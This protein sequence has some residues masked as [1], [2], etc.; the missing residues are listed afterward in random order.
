MTRREVSDA[1]FEAWL[2]GQLDDVRRGEV[3]AAVRR[4]PELL[5]RAAEDA[6]LRGAVRAEL[7]GHLGAPPPRSAALAAALGRGVRGRLAVRR[8]APLIAASLLVL[9]GWIGHAG[10][11]AAVPD[12]PSIPLEVLIVDEAA[13]A[14]DALL[15]KL[16]AGDGA[17]PR[18][19]GPVPGPEGL[20]AVGSDLVPWDRGVAW[21]GVY[22]A[23]GQPVT[24]FVAPSDGRSA[25]GPHAARVGS[26]TVVHWERDGMAYALAGSM[27]AAG[28]MPVAE[29][30][31][32]RP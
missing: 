1:D 26:L 30:A 28:L 25:V 2:D 7:D 17:F 20:E 24:L 18:Y 29:A 11:R 14:H 4:D 31:W 13:E 21:V 5:R 10:L 15:A 6:E 8:H 12:D 19:P 27:P 23:G 16:Q 3:E 32:K 9:L 22:R